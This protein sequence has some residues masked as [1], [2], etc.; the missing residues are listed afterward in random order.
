MLYLYTLILHFSTS[1][2]SVGTDGAH[3]SATERGWM[4]MYLSTHVCIEIVCNY[5]AISILYSIYYIDGLIL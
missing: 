2:K 3:L 4:Q 5:S 1:C